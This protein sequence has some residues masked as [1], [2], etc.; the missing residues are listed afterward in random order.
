MKLYAEKTEKAIFPSVLSRIYHFPCNV[1]KQK[2]SNATSYK[3][4]LPFPECFWETN[5][6]IEPFPKWQILDPSKLKEFQIL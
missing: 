3:H 4:F 1:S 6:I 2:V 5:L